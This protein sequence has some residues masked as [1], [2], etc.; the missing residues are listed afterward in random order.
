M[1]RVLRR[2]GGTAGL[3]L[4]VLAKGARTPEQAVQQQIKEIEPEEAK[5][6]KITYRMKVSKTY[7]K[8]HESQIFAQA[9]SALAHVNRQFINSAWKYTF[10]DRTKGVEAS[11]VTTAAQFNAGIRKMKNSFCDTMIKYLHLEDKYPIR[12]DIGMAELFTPQGAVINPQTNVPYYIELMH[13]FEDAFFGSFNIKAHPAKNPAQFNAFAAFYIMN[14]FDDI[15]EEQLDGIVHI[16]TANKGK[17]NNTVYAKEIARESSIYW[18]G[19]TH[20]AKSIENFTSHLAKLIISTIPKVVEVTTAADRAKGI[21]RFK[22]IG[23]QFL[24]PSDLYIMAG[25]LKEAEMD[26]NTIHQEE[27]KAGLVKPI[28]FN[29]NPKEALQ[30]LLTDK[31]IPVMKQFGYDLT[32]SLRAFLYSETETEY[33]VHSLFEQGIRLNNNTLDIESLLAFELNKNVTPTYIEYDDEGDARDR[34][35]GKQYKLS[36]RLDDNIRNLVFLESYNPNPVL[37][38][39]AYKKIKGK[40]LNELLKDPQNL[41]AFVCKELFNI[42]DPTLPQY[43]DFLEKHRVT[44]LAICEGLCEINGDHGVAKKDD[45]FERAVAVA[46]FVNVHILGKS[47]VKAKYQQLKWDVNRY[48]S[49]QALTN[50]DNLSGSAIPVYRLSSALFQYVQFIQNFHKQDPNRAK[51][52]FFID[53]QLVLSKYTKRPNPGEQV[54]VNSVNE[55]YTT[56]AGFMLDAGTTDENSE[57]DKMHPNDQLFVSFMGNWKSLKQMGMFACQIAPYSDKSSIGVILVNLQSQIFDPTDKSMGSDFIKSLGS[58]IDSPDAVTTLTRMDYFYRKNSKTK[59]ANNILKAWNLLSQVLKDKDGN[60]LPI[61]CEFLDDVELEEAYKDTKKLSTKLLSEINKLDSWLQQYGDKL[62][63]DQVALTASK[64]NIELADNVFYASLSRKGKSKICFNQS[65]KWMINNFS[66]LDSFRAYEKTLAERFTTSSEVQFLKERLTSPALAR[67][68][69]GAGIDQTKKSESQKFWSSILGVIY[70][71]T[72]KK[73]KNGKPIKKPKWIIKDEKAFNQMLLT[74]HYANNF[75]RSQY[76]DLISKDAFADKGSGKFSVDG[77]TS[78]EVATRIEA[79]ETKRLAG[80]P[81]TDEEDAFVKEALYT[82]GESE[83]SSRVAGM[84]KRMVLYPATIENFTQNTLRGVSPIVH[85]AIVKDVNEQVWNLKGETHGQEIFDGSGWVSVYYSYMENASLPGRGIKGTK[86]TLGVHVSDD[87][88][89]LFKWAEFELNNDR[90]RRSRGNKYELFELFKKM[91]N[92][93]QFGDDV[94][95]TKSYVV[96]DLKLKKPAQLVGRRMFYREGFNDFEIL[97]LKKSGISTYTLTV[98]KVDT[99]GQALPNTS[100]ETITKEVKSIFDL[101]ML[102]GSYNSMELGEDGKLVYSDIN[103]EAIY[104]YITRVGK[105]IDPTKALTQD[106][107]EQSLRD[108]FVSIVATK[109]AVKRGSANLNSGKSV[110]HS[111]KELATFEVSTK[112]FGVQLDANHHADM[113]QLTEMTQT[114]SAL[115]AN[116]HT[117]NLADEAYQAIADIIEGS[118]KSVRSKLSDMEMGH[119]ESVIQNLSKDIVEALATEKNLSTAQSLIA[120]IEQNIQGNLTLPISDKRFYKIFAKKIFGDLNKSSI[121]RKYTGLGGILNPSGN[122]LQMYQLNGKPLLFEDLVKMA[123]ESFK[124]KL[125]RD[126][127]QTYFKAHPEADQC[128]V[129][130]KLLIIRETNPE[131]VLFGSSVQESFPLIEKALSD[132]VYGKMPGYGLKLV[133]LEDINVLDSIAYYVTTSDLMQ[134]PILMELSDIEKFTNLKWTIKPTAVYFNATKPH[135]LRPQ[136]E[137]WVC[138]EADGTTTR[139]DTWSEPSM[140]MAYNVEHMLD[141]KEKLWKDPVIVLAAKNSPWYKM[142]KSLVFNQTHDIQATEQLLE[143]LFSEDA[144]NRTMAKI[145]VK[146]LLENLRMRSAELRVLGFD[147]GQLVE[148]ENGSG[149]DFNRYFCGYQINLEKSITEKDP[150]IANSQNLAKAIDYHVDPAEVIMPKLY[151]SNYNLGNVNLSEIDAEFFSKVNTYYKCSLIATNGVS[152]AP[153]DFLV[154]THTGNFNIMFTNKLGNINPAYGEDITSECRFQDGWRLDDDGNKLYKVPQKGQFAIFADAEGNETIII[155]KQADPKRMLKLILT[156]LDSKDSATPLVSV[157]PFLENLAYQVEITPQLIDMCMNMSHVKTHNLFLKEDRNLKGDRLIQALK[158]IYLGKESVYKQDLSNIL[159]N[160]FVKTLDIISTRIPTQAL[161]SFMAMHVVALTNDESNNVFVSRWQL[162]LQGSDLDIDKSYMMGVDVNRIGT[163]HHW[164]PLADYTTSELAKISDKLPLPAHIQITTKSDYWKYKDAI[165]IEETPNSEIDALLRD[166]IIAETSKLTADNK[167]TYLADQRHEYEITSNKK[168]KETIQQAIRVEL[169]KIIN[170]QKGHISMSPEFHENPIISEL[171]EQLNEHNAHRLTGSESRNCVAKA[172][173]SVSLDGRNMVSGYSPI[174]RAMAL[175]TDELANHTFANQLRNLDDTVSIMRIQY[176][177]AVGKQDVGIMANGLKAYFAMTQYFNAYWNSDDFKQS[178]RG[179]FIRALKIGKLGEAPLT[180]RETIADT[181]LDA[182]MVQTLTRELHRLDPEL[183]AKVRKISTSNDD[184]S[185]L[186]SSLVSLATDNAKELALAKLNAGINLACIHVFLTVM[187]YSA[188]DIVSYTTSEMFQDFTALIT[189]SQFDKN[190]KDRIDKNTWAKLKAK[191][192]DPKTNYTVED[193]KQLRRVYDSAQ[194]MTTLSKMLGINQG[195]KVDEFIAAEFTHNFQSILHDQ[196]KNV[197]LKGANTEKIETFIHNDRLIP[198]ITASSILK[199]LG[200]EMSETEKALPGSLYQV[201]L[202]KINDINE[203]IDDMGYRLGEEIDMSRYF[204]DSDYREFIVDLY[205]LFKENFN[206]YDILNH[207]KHFY[208]ML[209]AF[210]DYMQ[211]FTKTSSRARWALNDAFRIYSPHIILN[212]E[213]MEGYTRTIYEV[214]FR[215]DAKVGKKVSRL[216]D[217]YILSEFLQ[218]EDAY[219]FEFSL[220]GFGSRVIKINYGKGQ[221]TRNPN[222]RAFIEF[223]NLYL[224]PE[225]RCQHMDNKFIQSIELDLDA[226]AVDKHGK[227]KVTGKSQ[228]SWKFNFDIDNLTDASSESKYQDVVGGFDELMRVKDA[229]G[230]RFLTLGDVF[231]SANFKLGKDIKVGDI[232][233]LYDQ[234]LNF[235]SFGQGSL[236]KAFDH[237]IQDSPEIPLKIAQIEVEHDKGLRQM[238]IDKHILM[239]QVLR[240]TV[241]HNKSV[242]GVVNFKDGVEPIDMKEVI[243]LCVDQIKTSDN[244]HYR[245]CAKLLDA[246]R[247]NLIDISPIC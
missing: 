27:I 156:S 151:K 152:K 234:I 147:F 186:I 79:I 214:P 91:H 18:A 202:Q 60:P 174:D 212:K 185:L 88:S 243:L 228:I 120:A 58:I 123:R 223:V 231:P 105:V 78:D 68:L 118:L 63:W 34:N 232:L 142:L 240:N 67:T 37:T 10:L 155:R 242:N 192:E 104:G 15:V 225:L 140:F 179:K 107:V 125:E 44:I 137:H 4:G 35:Y 98:Q 241:L 73:D 217:D 16:T 116:G 224:I 124:S 175:F 239:A 203:R 162:W 153:V 215:Y 76:I 128:V 129:L 48:L 20:E 70:E 170:R 19:E 2:C 219:D 33:S 51:L 17:V 112:N 236:D 220:P 171:L 159:Y 247:F 233:Y 24:T 230:E 119:V 96:S 168:L 176:E 194:E 95:L 8:N 190:A 216:Y 157:Q 90:I 83:Y 167:D 164:S 127:I 178:D 221:K 149:Y 108:K 14:N 94:D 13:E 146:K 134:P 117:A 158:G 163:Y 122:V 92:K 85:V 204:S 87:N 28:I 50:F 21:H 187:G 32:T 64:H 188:A 199:N 80:M 193:V 201:L 210:N 72:D 191:A 81:I 226:I 110:W 89:A 1:A 101:W 65:L 245:K 169:L 148:L 121:K 29:D 31:S 9:D 197:A 227:L 208:Q 244:A 77:L 61:A 42:D 172:I 209:N 56:P 114:I 206:I 195:V 43:S 66:T 30:R 181:K 99:K 53:N 106:N 196:I 100:P 22:Q 40:S 57:V 54:D 74:Y 113:A 165:L 136:I 126:T 25:V 173:A 41:F 132:K 69:T 229:N 3:D 115:A 59:L 26:F 45:I 150:I 246:I 218:E 103:N 182:I 6:R 237:Y 97:N 109:A 154:R 130:A 198:G 205:D 161:Q 180:V 82:Y 141:P 213:Q 207:S 36:D 46:D 133:S 135:D 166:Y 39:E 200:I 111:D 71:S 84:A 75:V 49:A 38:G 183:A 143:D 23:D 55:F 177:N 11:F 138:Q 52:N 7:G 235:A 144:G 62:D 93:Y 47:G 139:K 238:N 189:P 5:E 131:T 86:K 145:Q 184:A 160:S 211:L 222:L 12:F 102:F